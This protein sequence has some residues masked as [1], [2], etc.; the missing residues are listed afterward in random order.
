VIFRTSYELTDALLPP[1]L[2]KKATLTAEYMLGNIKVI[3]H[4]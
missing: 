1:S 2:L 3:G 4:C